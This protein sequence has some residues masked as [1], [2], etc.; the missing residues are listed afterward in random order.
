MAGIK[1]PHE[2]PSPAMGDAIH[3]SRKR[4][5]E[6]TEADAALAKLYNDLADDVHDVRIAA[7][8]SLV[9]NLNATSPEQRVDR[10]NSAVGRLVKGLCSG[11]KAA[12]LGFSVALT[13]VLGLG[14]ELKDEAFRLHGVLARV[15]ELT[16]VQG[17]MSGQ[18]RRDYLLGRRFAYQAVLQSEVAA[19]A[20]VSLVEWREFVSAVLELMCEKQWLRR[21]CGTMVYEWLANVRMA[22]PVERLQVVVDGFGVKGMWK[23]PEG[24]AIWMLLARRFEGVKL[25]K[26]VW[27]HNDPLSSSERALL[28]KVLQEVPIDDDHAQT[29]GKATAGTRQAAPSFAW[30]VILKELLAEERYERNLEDFPKFWKQAVDEGLFG[31]S[32]SPE[33]KA[34]GLQVFSLAILLAARW[35]IR[36]LFT[37]NLMRCILNQRASTQSYLF[38][39]AKVPLNQLIAQSKLDLYATS[40]IVEGLL[41]VAV[42]FDQVTKTKTIETLLSNTNAVAL[43]DVVLV[44]RSFMFRPSVKSDDPSQVDVQRR[45]VADML[46]SMIRSKKE[47]G[48]LCIKNEDMRVGVPPRWIRDA[49]HTLLEIGFCKPQKPPKGEQPSVTAVSDASR[50]VCR[51]RFSSCIGHLMN[52]PLADAASVVY[53][54]VKVLRSAK[55]AYY[56]KSASSEAK[57]IVKRTDKALHDASERQWFA[58]S[59][60]QRDAA[61]AFTL[62]FAMSVYQVYNDEPDAVSALQDLHACAGD[63]GKNTESAAVLTELLLSFVSKQSALFR[64]LAEQVF[65][66]FTGSLTAD[67]LQSMLDVLAQKESL[68]GQEELFRDVDDDKDEDSNDTDADGQSPIDVD[69]MSDVELTNGEEAAEQSSDDDDAEDSD[70]D[71]EEDEEDEEEIAAFDKKLADALGPAKVNEDGEEEDDDSDM[72]D[73]QMMAIEPALQNVFKELKKKAGKKQDNKDA[74]DNIVNFKNRVLDLL[75]IYVKAQHSNILAVDLITPLTVLTRTTANKPTAEKA[76][77]V[78]KQYFDTCTKQK[79]LPP[80]HDVENGFPLLAELHEEMEKDGSKLHANACSRSSLFLAKVMTSIDTECF[81]RIAEVYADTQA[82]WWTDPKS[83]VHASV[84]TEWTSW[85]IATKVRS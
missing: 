4:R 21:E 55:H 36:Q 5:V 11:R 15:A 46:L 51:Q 37:P 70:D 35:Q 19:N 38:D 27:Q 74:K 41:E 61:S 66:A 26:S 47:P 22:P 24:V 39:A 57:D 30:S 85:A 2:D 6:Y 67:G 54:L 9:R 25:P 69:D 48:E 75:S 43:S 17:N 53:E 65:T 76:F 49:L 31:A 78:L 34:L 62:L 58:R 32:S 68:S 77:A 14:F 81:E 23:T 80:L 44:L 72:D 28:S 33:R 20:G 73:E 63:W 29:G 60:P 45:Q 79:S 56:H 52:L 10:I 84:F 8:G 3:P 1:R 83:K 16:T 64:K 82:K 50:T 7:A 42:N 13:V 59:Q 12:R 71:E 18:E 40:S